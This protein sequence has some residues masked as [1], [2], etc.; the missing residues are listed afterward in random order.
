MLVCDA[1]NMSGNASVHYPVNLSDINVYDGG[2]A[3][4]SCSNFNDEWLILDGQV[5]DS[6]LQFTCSGKN[7]SNDFVNYDCIPKRTMFNT[8]FF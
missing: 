2:I 5:F 3:I 4:V 1:L 6:S 7:W 8:T